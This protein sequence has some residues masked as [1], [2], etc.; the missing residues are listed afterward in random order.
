[1]TFLPNGGLEL[2]NRTIYWTL[3]RDGQNIPFWYQEST[4]SVIF[5]SRNNR[6]PKDEGFI[7]EVK[8][9]INYDNVLNMVKEFRGW[10][11][12]FEHMMKGTGPCKIEEPREEPY[13]VLIDIYNEE[14]DI[15]MNYNEL[16]EYSCVFNIP[17]VELWSKQTPITKEDIFN[18]VDKLLKDCKEHKFEGV[19]G[20]VYDSKPQYMFKE[21]ISLP[22]TKKEKTKSKKNIIVLPPL[23]DDQVFSA[24]GQAFVECERNGYDVKDPKLTMPIV[25]NHVNTQADEHK[26]SSPAEIFIYYRKYLEMNH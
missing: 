22:K 5:G 24:I 20:K 18:M 15:F 4:D 26:C 12:Y 3:K 13:L 11:F 17:L 9:S 23:T 8:A 1:M 19:V 2:I 7:R 25:V 10:V 16:K 21:K 6:I 14:H